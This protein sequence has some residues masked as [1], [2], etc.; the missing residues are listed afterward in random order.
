MTDAPRGL[1]RAFAPGHPA[2]VAYVL[3]GYPDREASLAALAAVARAGAGVIELGVPYADAVADGPV[4]AEAGKVALAHG[5][6]LA[7]T[8]ALASE[9]LDTHGAAPPIAL[10]TY[11]NPMM[12]LGFPRVAELAAEAGVSG[13]IVPDLPP[14]SPMA[15]RWL[16][17][18]EP[19]GIETGFRAAPTSTPARLDALGARARLRVRGVLTW[20]D[21]GAR[22]ACG[23][24]A[25][26]CGARPRTHGAAGS[27]GL[28][29]E[30]RRAGS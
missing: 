7:E 3:A 24:P 12:R 15:D 10:M 19:L 26:A 27:R 5:F 11:L 20:R 6:G 25:R 30:H 28:R 13:F 22:R 21:G 8:I 9:F 23:W 18:S 16:A 1:A 29:R 2:L 17:A 14:D 4:I